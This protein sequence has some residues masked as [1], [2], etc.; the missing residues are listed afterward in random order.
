M[1]LRRNVVVV[2][3]L[4]LVVVGVVFVDCQP[5]RAALPRWP[6]RTTLLKAL[7]LMKIQRLGGWC[8]GHARNL[9]P[10]A[11]TVRLGGQAYL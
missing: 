8:L 7:F 2:V 3:L 9:G 5:F 4:V 11:R 10:R 1:S 6:L